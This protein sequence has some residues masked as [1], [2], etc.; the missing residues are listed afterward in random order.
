MMTLAKARELARHDPLNNEWFMFIEPK[1]HTGWQGTKCRW[2][3][4]WLGFFVPE[5]VVNGHFSANDFDVESQVMIL[6]PNEE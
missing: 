5:G 4:P 3:D 1:P 6:T 2:L